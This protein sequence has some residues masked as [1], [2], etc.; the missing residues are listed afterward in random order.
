MLTADFG[1][2]AGVEAGSEDKERLSADKG[3]SQAGA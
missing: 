1:L 2:E 3:Q